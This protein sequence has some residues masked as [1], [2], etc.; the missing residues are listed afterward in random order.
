MPGSIVP[1]SAACGDGR[2][3]ERHGWEEVP[4]ASLL[5]G[6]Y[7]ETEDLVH[8][9]LLKEGDGCVELDDSE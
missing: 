5:C 6:S 4:G 1:W 2:V 9:L 8:F 3:S 7:P